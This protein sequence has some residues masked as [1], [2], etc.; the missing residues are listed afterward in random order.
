MQQYQ[1][2][3]A[4]CV[5]CDLIAL[6]RLKNFPPAEIPVS[7]VANS[8]EDIESRDLIYHEYIPITHKTLTCIIQV[9]NRKY[10]HLQRY[11]A[12]HVSRNVIR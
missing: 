10:H 12:I 1:E 8:M 11:G 6:I 3:V 7:Y 4:G 2:T 9:L 5:P